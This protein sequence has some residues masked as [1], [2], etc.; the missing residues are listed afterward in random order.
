MQGCPHPPHVAGLAWLQSLFS[1]QMIPVESFVFPLRRALKS[2]ASVCSGL[3][4]TML[5]VGTAPLPHINLGTWNCYNRKS[6]SFST[7]LLPSLKQVNKHGLTCP[8]NKNQSLRFPHDSD[9]EAR[10]FHLPPVCPAQ[11][12]PGT[13]SC[14]RRAEASPSWRMIEIAG[15]C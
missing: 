10:L 12:A 6:F 8:S 15:I 3:E 5:T 1:K 2:P 14:P 7:L 9:R 4:L 11:V 13:L